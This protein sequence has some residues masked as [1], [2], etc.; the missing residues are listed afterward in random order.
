MCVS[1][2]TDHTLF[3]LRCTIRDSCVSYS[4]YSFL[5]SSHILERIDWHSRVALSNGLCIR[6]I[7][8]EQHTRT[9]VAVRWTYK[10]VILAHHLLSIFSDTEGMLA[11]VCWRSNGERLM[12]H[13][14][15]EDHAMQFCA[16]G[17]PLDK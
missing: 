1:R 14:S 6:A 11:N 12:Q 4:I 15:A 3:A 5:V 9:V 10:G 8:Y 13:T 16:Q 2:S 17:N 7:L